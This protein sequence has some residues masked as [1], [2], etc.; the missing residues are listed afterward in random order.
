MGSDEGYSVCVYCAASAA[1]PPRYLL[2]ATDVGAGIAKR[3]WRLV[4]G[5]QNVSMMGAVASAA[6]RGGARTLGVIPR[7]LVERAVADTD[8]DELLVTDDL[9]DRKA[10]MA[11]NANAFLVLPG[12]IGTCEELFEVWNARALELHTKPVVLLDPD[13]HYAGLLGWMEDMRRS[14]FITAAALTSLV[15]TSSVDAALQACAV[16]DGATERVTA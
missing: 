2:L 15:H 5:G 13:G 1:A 11:A 14:G 7:A 4:S 10:L 6:R 12:G 9:R 3:G 16:N 8:A